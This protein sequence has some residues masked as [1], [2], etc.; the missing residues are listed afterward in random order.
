MSTPRVSIIISCFNLGM[1]LEEALDS[2]IS[3]TIQ[4]WECIIIND[5]SNDLT[6]EIALYHARKDSRFKYIK[7]GNKGLSESRNTGLNK[8]KGE[9][10]QFLDAD[11]L[12]SS[13]KLESQLSAFQKNSHIDIV[14][15]EYLCF[16]DDNKQI[17]WTYSRILL[18]DPNIKDFIL[19]W[20]KDLSIPIHCFLFRMSC[21]TRWGQFDVTLPNHEDWDLHIRF[22]N[23][24]ARYKM[25][26]GKTAFYR[27]RN[28]SMARNLL[29]MAKGRNL[30]IDKHINI[31]LL[32]FHF[33]IALCER[34]IES[35]IHSFL[36][37]LKNKDIFQLK[38]FLGIKPLISNCYLH[39]IFL[40][41]ISLFSFLIRTIL[42]LLYRNIRFR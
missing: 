37:S 32:P 30:L 35:F 23:F 17:T 29:E 36:I 11:D 15:S 34:K 3:Q 20:E 7:Q 39:S 24:G 9:F 22:A 6:H 41:S 33:K 19:N 27:I 16:K 26:P 2:L 8:A 1:Y 38:Q 28:H 4:D 5:G 12:I 42:G 10:I 31:E 21:F 13:N 25:V 40:I 14:Y 18:N